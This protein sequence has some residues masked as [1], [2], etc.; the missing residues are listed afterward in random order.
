MLTSRAWGV[1]M[2]VGYQSWPTSFP[3]SWESPVKKRGVDRPE[4][5]AKRLS[6]K[7][8]IKIRGRFLSTTSQI[9]NSS[10]DCFYSI[11]KR[12]LMLPPFR[13]SSEELSESDLLLTYEL[14]KNRNN[15]GKLPKISFLGTI[16]IMWPWKVHWKLYL[17]ARI[18]NQR[19]FKD[20]S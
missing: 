12:C 8:I 9:A 19:S 2:S 3:L 13:C 16:N 7:N 14:T 1:W 18:Y 6:V 11:S 15:K 20:L 17:L 10:R 5:S 4:V